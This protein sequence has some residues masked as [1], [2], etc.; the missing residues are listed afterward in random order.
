VCDEKEG[1]TFMEVVKRLVAA[2][3]VLQDSLRGALESFET[4]SPVIRR[5]LSV[6]IRRYLSVSM[7]NTIDSVIS[8]VRGTFR[9]DRGL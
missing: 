4:M 1:G 2:E 7:E 6:S 5:Y 9:G 3:K 8:T